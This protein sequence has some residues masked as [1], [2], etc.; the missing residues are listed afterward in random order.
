MNLNTEPAVY[1]TTAFRGNTASN[2][3]TYQIVNHELEH[4]RRTRYAS[5]YKPISP[6]VCGRGLASPIS[7]KTASTINAQNMEYVDMY[8]VQPD[9]SNNMK[10]ATNHGA[11]DSFTPYGGVMKVVTIRGTT[12]SNTTVHRRDIQ[13]LPSVKHICQQREHNTN[14]AVEQ[15]HYP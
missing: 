10:A 6:V 14:S 3:E 8:H 7:S 15:V 2:D 1:A 13:I 12:D 11:N 9:T 4:S 5:G